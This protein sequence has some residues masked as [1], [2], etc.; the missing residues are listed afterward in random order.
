[1]TNRET[2]VSV[3]QGRVFREAWI[4]GV[5]AHYPGEPKLA[6]SRPGTRRRTGSGRAPR[7]STSRSG[8]CRAVGRQHGQAQSRAEG[9]V[10]DPVLD[11]P[12]LQASP[13]RSWRISPAGRTCRPG[14]KRRMRTSLSG[15]SKKRS[16]AALVSMLA[17]P[18]RSATARVSASP[19]CLTMCP[20][21]EVSCKASRQ[22]LCLANRRTVTNRRFD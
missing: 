13:T 4:A 9:P 15:L 19:M 12:D 8:V 10:R 14:S 7:P 1:M 11:R 5:K 21:R 16:R 22:A 2:N 6:T 20:S 3:E 18:E 17:D